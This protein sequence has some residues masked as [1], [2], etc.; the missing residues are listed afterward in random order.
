MLL[1]ENIILAI[2]SLLSNK[3]RALLTMLGIIIGI[4][5][6][7]AILT[8]GDSLTI[9]ITEQMQSQGANDIY[10]MV[11]ARKDEEENSKTLDGAVYGKLNT[12]AEMTSSDMITDDMIK[13][14]VDAYE[15]EIYAV[16]VQYSTNTGTARSGSNSISAQILGASAGYYI[17]NE[18]NMNAGRM[19]SADD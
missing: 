2:N 11:Q 19:F 14:L 12:Q 3:M 15:K 17:T 6:V 9:F 10:V 4:G 7:I 13:E 8:V 5:S 16:N 1:I 18:L